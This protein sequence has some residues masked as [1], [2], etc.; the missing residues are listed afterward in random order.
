MSVFRRINIFGWL[1]GEGADVTALNELK[2]KDAA[3]ANMEQAIGAKTDAVASSDTGDFSQMSFWKRLMQKMTSLLTSLDRRSLRA[4]ISTSNNFTGSLT[5]GNTQSGTGESMN[6]HPSV[7]CA[8]FSDQ[9]LTLYMEQSIDNI[10]WDSSIPYVV[11]ANVNEVHRLT[12]TREY[13]RYRLVNNSGAT[14]NIRMTSTFAQFA[15]LTSA[16]NSVIQ[17]DADANVARIIDTET[18]IGGGFLDGFSVT[19]KAGY[20]PD[21]DT[22]SIPEDIGG[23]GGVYAGFPDSTLETITV[24]SSSILDTALGTGARSVTIIGLDDLYNPI[25][26]T[27]ATNGILG[28]TT[29]Q[30]FRRN[31]TSFVASGVN[32]GT[33]T[34]RHTVTITNVFGTMLP[35]TN[36]TNESA[37]TVP[38]GFTGL[39]KALNVSISQ[40]T[41]A[42]SARGC[43]WTRAFGMPFRQRRPFLVSNSSK[44][45]QEPY[46][47]IR[48]TEKSDIVVRIN[49]VSNN[50]TEVVAEYDIILIRN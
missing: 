16:L 43:F 11:R 22:G 29:T 8:L 38:A 21:I 20:N 5:T 36:Q 23:T 12:R 31:H 18:L 27:I 1:S 14:A 39:A 46:G 2:T 4:E 37:F 42:A 44:S 10:N 9:D 47:G 45:Q 7:I 32:V 28:A 19:Q 6:G 13:Y 24:I 40:G 25:Q 35:G 33:L 41:A 50:N 34:F 48:F 49:S 15:Q 17:Q 3:T 30:Q 26:E